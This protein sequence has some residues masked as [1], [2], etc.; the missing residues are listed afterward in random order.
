[1]IW[2]SVIL[3]VIGLGLVLFDRWRPFTI[4]RRAAT[5]GL[6]VCC[7][8][9]A[10]GLFMLAWSTSIKVSE[11]YDLRRGRFLDWDVLHRYSPSEGMQLGLCIAGIGGLCTF[12]LWRNPARRSENSSPLQARL[13]TERPSRKL[14]V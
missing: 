8:T 5:S 4:P 14:D 12:L 1:M 3:A 11:I 2:L 13:V 10:Y 6:V 9:A 7:S